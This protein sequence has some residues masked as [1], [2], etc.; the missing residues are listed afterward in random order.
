MKYLLTLRFITI[1]TYIFFQSQWQ[2]FCQDQVQQDF[3]SI[4]N[5]IIYMFIY[6]NNCQD[7]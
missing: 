5:L 3:V 4:Q 7:R 6:K 2:L 1:N